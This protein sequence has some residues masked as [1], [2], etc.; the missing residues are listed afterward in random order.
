VYGVTAGTAR[1]GSGQTVT[2]TNGTTTIMNVGSSS[3][4]V[5]YQLTNGTHYRYG[6]FKYTSTG[7]V[8]SYDDEYNESTTNFLTA[9]LH[10]NATGTLTCYVNATATLKYNIRQFI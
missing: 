8:L 4:V 5:N 6:M 3:G 9:N 10:A 7:G 2:L 1:E